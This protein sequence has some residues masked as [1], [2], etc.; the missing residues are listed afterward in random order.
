MREFRIAARLWPLLRRYRWALAATVVLGILSSLAEGFGITLFLPLLET[1][2]G[3]FPAAAQRDRL[4]HFLGS[5]LTGIPQSRRLATIACLILALTFCKSLLT[6]GHSALAARFNSRL[7]H[8]IRSGVYSKMLDVSQAQLT[9]MGLGRLINLLATDTWHT[10]DALSLLISLVINLCSICVFSLMLLALS[11]RLTFLVL[12]AV[13]IVSLLL[14]LITAAARRLGREGVEANSELSEQMLDGLEGLR[15]IQ[16]LGLKSHRQALF[17]AASEKVRSIFWTLERL[18]RA[19]PPLSELLYVG[20]L[21]GLLLAG[22]AG[23]TSGSIMIIFLLVLYRLQPQIRQW[24]SNRLSLAALARSVEDVID[25]Y[26]AT[27]PLEYPAPA[28]VVRPLE[29]E[30]RFDQVSYCYEDQPE[31]ALQGA[32]LRLARGQTTAI[33]GPSGSGKTTLVSL[34]CGFYRPVAGEI[35]VDGVP[36]AQCDL[37]GWRSQIAWVSQGAHIFN[38]SIRENIRYGR[39]DADDDEVIEAAMRADAH[40]FITCL[41]FGYDTRVGN[42]EQQLSTGQMQRI[43]LARAFLRKA[44]LL[45]LDEAT[46]SLDSLSEDVVQEF[47]RDRPV[48]QTVIVISHRLSSVKFADRA[49]VLNAG[50]VAETGSPREL[51]ARKGLFSKLKE[52][53]HVE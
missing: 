42:S 1:L 26:A 33:I 5:L 43:A 18:H 49:I 17:E 39:L 19:I 22:I 31:F 11:W 7:I 46:N 9:R 24:D 41:P 40:S 12:A 16:M 8:A 37:A 51:A 25:F 52:L 2:D 15:E 21:L 47:L 45:I 6:Y 20:L 30:I 28:V 50:R 38:A 34:L 10:G 36:L 35:R 48:G 13:V 27:P 3:Q 29:R 32:S 23:R 4:Q 44:D 53:Q 14:R